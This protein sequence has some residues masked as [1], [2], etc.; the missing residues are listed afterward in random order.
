MI[1][2]ERCVLQVCGALRVVI[3]GVDLTSRLPAG[4]ARLLLVFLVLRRGQLVSR[5]ELVDAL[6]PASPPEHGERDVA[7]LLS[8][9]RAVLGAECL[10]AGPQSAV[11][12][13]DHARVDLDHANR[14]IQRA[15]SALAASDAE[16]AWAAALDALEVARRGFLPGVALPWADRQRIRLR[17]LLLESYE[18]IGEAGLLLGGPRLATAQRMGMEIVA[19]EPLR[20]GGYRLAMRA[21]IAR[22]NPAEALQVY[23]L[24]RVRLRD[25]LGVDPGP[26]S[27]ALFET[28]LA[29]SGGP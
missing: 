19:E 28:I 3:D 21:C 1:D 16:A 20:E 15:E 27:R 5:T 24:L 26:E 2:E 10:P 6:W 8:R 7:A 22:G 4:Q 14:S 9:L 13:P 11:L 25:D 18:L 29:A 17:D 23:D 12:L